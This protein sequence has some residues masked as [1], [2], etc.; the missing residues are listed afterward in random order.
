MTNRDILGADNAILRAQGDR[1]DGQ[2]GLA[3]LLDAALGRIGAGADFP[4]GHLRL[5]RARIWGRHAF[6]L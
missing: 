1:C 5:L 6:G 4:T 3:L 2:G